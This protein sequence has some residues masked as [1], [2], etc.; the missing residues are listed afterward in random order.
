MYLPA[1]SSVASQLQKD[2]PLLRINLL[3]L[4]WDFQSE[5]TSL[6]K[7]YTPEKITHYSLVP[8][9]CPFSLYTGKPI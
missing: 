6:S 8:S 5:W 2:D 7:K 4:Q 3:L 9:L 1:N